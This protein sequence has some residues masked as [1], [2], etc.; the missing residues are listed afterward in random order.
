MRRTLVPLL[1]LAALSPAAAQNYPVTNLAPNDCSGAI[2]LGGTAQIAIAASKA[3]HGYILQ[4]IDT[5]E[6]LWESPTGTAAAATPGSFAL[7]AATPTTFA[8]AGSFTTPPGFGT[9]LALSVV[10][11][12]TGHKFSC[13]WW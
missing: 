12:T 2:T 6:P 10:A 11:A 4:N 3:A 7:A 8:G 9:A 13:A 5:T 1:F